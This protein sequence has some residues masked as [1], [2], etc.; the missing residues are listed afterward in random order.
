MT[1]EQRLSDIENWLNINK[2]SVASF[3]GRLNT[4]AQRLAQVETITDAVLTSNVTDLVDRVKMN[5]AKAACH[6]G[7]AQPALFT[8]FDSLEEQSEK[9]AAPHY[10][11]DE[12]G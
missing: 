4:L 1:T 10:E 8:L 12:V 2:D 9:I 5:E 6:A 11:K 7:F 3:N